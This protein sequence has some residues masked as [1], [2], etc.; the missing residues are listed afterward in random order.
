M[1]P[2][3]AISSLV[4][5]AIIGAAALTA[6]SAGAADASESPVSAYKVGNQCKVDIN[7]T[8]LIKDISQVF[9]VSL[10]HS[11]IKDSLNRWLSDNRFAE[12]TGYDW[13]QPFPDD[14]LLPWEDK[15]IFNFNTGGD[16]KVS[17]LSRWL[18]E[19]HR[20]MP[21]GD[22]YTGGAILIASGGLAT[23]LKYP[24]WKHYSVDSAYD[25]DPYAKGISP[26]DRATIQLNLGSVVD[27]NGQPADTAIKEQEKV[28]NHLQ[29]LY[30]YYLIEMFTADGR[31]DKPLVTTEFL[32]VFRDFENDPA[33]RDL[34]NS[35]LEDYGLVDSNGQ[36]TMD[37]VVAACQEAF[38]VTPTSTPASTSA[39]PTSTSTTAP[40]TT[41]TKTTTS[42]TSTTSGPVSSWV[43]PN[44]PTSTTSKTTSTTSK[45]STTST[46]A[47]S[48][49]TSTSAEPSTTTTT[50][51]ASTTSQQ[52]TSEKTSTTSTSAKPSTT[53]TTTKASTTSPQS[54][55][56]KSTTSTSTTTSKE[57]TT[58]TTAGSFEPE[59]TSVTDPTSTTT[60]G[61]NGSGSGNNGAGTDGNGSVTGADSSSTTANPGE[62][63]NVGETDG[64]NNGGSTT[65]TTPAT[66]TSNRESG[67]GGSNVVYNTTSQTTVPSGG[68]ENN[69]HWGSSGN[70]AEQQ[71][72]GSSGSSTDSLPMIAA[73]AVI[74]GLGG[75]F[76]FFYSFLHNSGVSLTFLR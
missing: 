5:S 14:V 40:S 45:S 33:N 12:E 73:L 30:S 51:N 69:G 48:S 1:S 67:N 21:G 32:D 68:V 19:K 44:Q 9:A 62:A 63:S 55:S 7:E 15:Y 31:S 54:T 13:L 22:G 26:I 58:S 57:E 64:A 36:P 16:F 37:H 76:A 27:A 46:T 29:H 61:N 20:D 60:T 17:L 72:S 41:S 6:P 74:F 8:Q 10:T 28:I 18:K 2:K 75:I 38:G 35:F 25:T 3:F 52:S 23:D 71:G 34:I 53:T 65:T 66:S 70:K 43:N 24:L 39:A 4:A 49:T 59:V 47:K 56:E 42:T 11:P 50:S